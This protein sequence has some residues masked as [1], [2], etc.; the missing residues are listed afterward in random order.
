MKK[1][2]VVCCLVLA[3]CSDTTGPEIP[4]CTVF[5]DLSVTPPTVT[6]TGDC[7]MLDTTLTTITVSGD[8]LLVRDGGIG[9]HPHLAPVIPSIIAVLTNVSSKAKDT[10]RRFRGQP[11]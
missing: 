7:S 10:H 9:F 3:A 11:C 8:T 4:K 1:L 5:F 6:H 2:L